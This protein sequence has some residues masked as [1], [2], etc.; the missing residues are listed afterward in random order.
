M[1]SWELVRLGGPVLLLLLALS[2]ATL[3]LVLLKAWEFHERELGARAFAGRALD[4]W[5]RG[6]A[7]QALAQL[8]SR[9][10]P[11]AEVMS[12]AMALRLR[13]ELPEPHQREQIGQLAADRLEAT[14]GLLR[15]LEVITGLAPLLGL[16]GTVL[17]MIEVFQRL[18][19]AG[20]RVDVALLAGGLWEA[21][22]TTA[23][24]LGVALLALAAFHFFDRK[25]ERLR[26]DMESALTRIFTAPL[27]RA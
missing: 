2:V 6:Q 25:H 19:L 7:D 15:P 21:L 18:Q 20:E 10:S 26:H 5:A 13:G 12:A 22:L 8:G 24:G 1:D 3:T 23:A 14:R 9:N 4:S 11:L 16:L 27:P 17:G